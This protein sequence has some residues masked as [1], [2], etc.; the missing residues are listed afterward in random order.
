M[1]TEPDLDDPTTDPFDVAAAAA[2]YIAAKTG[3]SGHDVALVLGSGWGGAAELIGDVVAEIP[4][5]DIPG[6]VKP[7]VE[8]HR[9]TTRSIRIERPDGAVRH[10]LV[11]GSR[12]HL[13]EGRGVRRVAHGVRTAAA[14][15][16]ETVILTN[17]CG[18]VH[19]GWRPGQVVLLKDHLNLTGQ[20]PLEGAKFAD[21]TN[22]YTPRLREI[23]RSVD[24]DLPEGVYAQFHGPQYETPAEV[25]MASL[26]GAD[27]VGMSTAVEAVAARHSRMD[28]L[29]ISL[30]TN[31]AAGISPTPLAHEEVLEAGRQAGP[32]ISDLLAKIVKQI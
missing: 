2:E 24:P 13:Y 31:L 1:S 19:I 30:A 10:A 7:A 11:L 17:G 6:F 3:V 29:G 4:T 26:L 32:R 9:S 12:T 27:L 5:A 23:A 28:V 21:M 20:T 15:G 14:A 25:K 16:C 8:G 22:I 18:S